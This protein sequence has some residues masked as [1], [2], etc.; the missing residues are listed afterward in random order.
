[1]PNLMAGQY[2]TAVSAV[3]RGLRV[4]SLRAVAGK[5]VCRPIDTLS[6]AEARAL[7]WEGVLRCFMTLEQ[8]IADLVA[9]KYAAPEGSAEYRMAERQLNGLRLTDN[10]RRPHHRR[11]RLVRLG[12]YSRPYPA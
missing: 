12:S 3:S 5:K 2:L 10:G 11:I 1:M 8:T 9:R 6:W 7:A 4:G